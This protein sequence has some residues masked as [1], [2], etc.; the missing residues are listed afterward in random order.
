DVARYV[1]LR[2]RVRGRVVL[3]ERIELTG[4]IRVAL[5][6]EELVGDAL[7]HVVGLAGEHQQGL[8]LRLPA[9]ARDR[10]VVS[11]S[12]LAAG[13]PERRLLRGVG[14]LVREDDVV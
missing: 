10:A 1:R 5:V 2:R 13:D 6:A 12:V 8:V 4:R 9:E 11:R 3:G 14:A 7:L